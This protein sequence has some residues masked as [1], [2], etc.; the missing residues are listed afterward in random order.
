LYRPISADAAKRVEDGILLQG[1]SSLTLP[2]KLHIVDPYTV[3]L[4]LTEGRFHQ[5]KRMFFAIGNRVKSLHRQRIGGLE[6]DVDSGHWRSLT[7]AEV[8]ALS[9]HA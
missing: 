6:L 3:L 4:T 7:Q 8:A 9:V 1:E 5:V 2:A